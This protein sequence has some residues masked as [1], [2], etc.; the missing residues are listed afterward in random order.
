M[1]KTLNSNKIDF[2]DIFKPF[3]YRVCYVAQS[4]PFILPSRVVFVVCKTNVS[5]ISIFFPPSCPLSFPPSRVQ[6][7]TN[8]HYDDKNITVIQVICHIHVHAIR[9]PE[10]TE[11]NH[12]NKLSHYFDDLRFC[13]RNIE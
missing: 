12:G 5:A 2:R 7:K 3:R 9:R 13:K 6:L 10:T 1:I 11:I 8:S 4:K